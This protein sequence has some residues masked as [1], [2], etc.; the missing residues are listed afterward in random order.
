VAKVSSPGGPPPTCEKCLKPMTFRAF[1]PRVTDS[2]KVSL[3]ECTNC[4]R[5]TFVHRV[6]LPDRS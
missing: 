5:T 3:Y 2:S 1:L 4:G 6:D